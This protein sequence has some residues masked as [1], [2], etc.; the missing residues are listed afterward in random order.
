M[1]VTYLSC[2][3]KAVVG[4]WG[5]SEHPTTISVPAGG[6]HLAPCHSASLEHIVNNNQVHLTLEV[7]QFN[8]QK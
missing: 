7:I 5:R 2:P 1:N 8:I 3:V 4:A 6:F